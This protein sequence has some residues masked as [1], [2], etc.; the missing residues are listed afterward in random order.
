MEKIIV[1]EGKEHRG[2]NDI[3]SII[4]DLVCD[5][6][7][8]MEESDRKK[9]LNLKATA[10]TMKSTIKIK[11][12]YDKDAFIVK[13]EL[14]YLLSLAKFN[15]ILLLERINADILCRGL[16]KT[17]YSKNYVVVNK[18]ADELLKNHFRKDRDD[19]N[20]LFNHDGR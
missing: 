17:G 2:Y 6:F 12:T 15:R 18:V 19:K 7:Y 4:K 20:G 3:E 8:E 5:D 13:D 16:D 10:N 11:D 1:I 14:T 9:Q